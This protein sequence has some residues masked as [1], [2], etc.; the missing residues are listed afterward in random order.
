M[1]NFF[2]LICITALYFGCKKEE[3][4]EEP[5]PVPVIH[6]I[7]DVTYNNGNKLEYTYDSSDRVISIKNQAHSITTIK[8]LGSTIKQYFAWAF[9]LDSAIFFLNTA[10]Y[11][12]SSFSYDT[13]IG[14]VTYSSYTFNSLGYITYCKTNYFPPAEIYYTYQND[15]L[16]KTVEIFAD[17][18]ET[19]YSYDTTLLNNTN[20]ELYPEIFNGGVC[21]KPSKNLVKSFTVRKGSYIKTYT[22]QNTVNNDGYLITTRV[23]DDLTP[24]QTERNFS[25]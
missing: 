14:Q 15:N 16:T 25:Y 3:I 2:I 8:Y 7:K 19:N 11:P 4:K 18:V 20:F 9:Y 1:K 17:T 21:V 24:D 12:D 23:T 5:D 10:G 22:V 6:K 13:Q